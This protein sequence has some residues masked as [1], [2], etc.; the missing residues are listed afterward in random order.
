MSRL[1]HAGCRLQVGCSDALLAFTKPT[2]S[3]H[4]CV[5][6]PSHPL[7]KILERGLHLMNQHETINNAADDIMMTRPTATEFLVL[8]FTLSQP[9]RGVHLRSLHLVIMSKYNSRCNHSTCSK[10]R[11]EPR[12]LDIGLR[13]DMYSI[14]R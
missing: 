12:N 5:G 6:K 2:K 9:C 3:S 11:I 14:H 13:I 10:A 4:M 7:S 8:I 1:A